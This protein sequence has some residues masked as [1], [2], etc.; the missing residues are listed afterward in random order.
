MFT[1]YLASRCRSIDARDISPVALKRAIERCTQLPNVRFEL[2]D[3]AKDEIPG[4]YDLV[5]AMD[6][7]SCIRGRR[8]LA[9]ATAKLVNALREGGVLVYTDNSMPL[10]VLRSW[11]SHPW[12]GFFFSM[13]EPDDC[14]RFLE[15]QFPLQLVYREQYLHD[16]GGR[17]QLIALLQ[18]RLTP[19]RKAD[20]E[21]L[22]NP[23]VGVAPPARYTG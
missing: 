19:D 23:V 1:S 6:I 20:P 2:M 15:N 11:G 18:K 22:D 12:W 21:T 10:E 16:P 3:L 5:F 7:L 13:M 17:D 9:N 8:H 14:V 4:K